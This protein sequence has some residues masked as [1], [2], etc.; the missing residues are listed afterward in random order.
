M[1]KKYKKLTYLG[2][3]VCAATPIGRLA[4]NDHCKAAYKEMNDL[5][6]TLFMLIEKSGL[7]TPNIQK[8]RKYIIQYGNKYYCS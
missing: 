4:I 6:S 8:L 3:K 2:L 1:V 7:S 5:D